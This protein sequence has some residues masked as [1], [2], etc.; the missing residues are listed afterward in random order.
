MNIWTS[1]IHIEIAQLD[2]RYIFT[3]NV[4]EISTSNMEKSITTATV[5][6][7]TK[8]NFYLK[9]LSIRKIFLHNS[10]LSHHLGQCSQ[11]SLQKRETL[12]NKLDQSAT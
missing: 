9:Y 4:Y 3:H 12:S 7:Q 10:L 8:N 5:V 11:R 1:L 2:M 6:F